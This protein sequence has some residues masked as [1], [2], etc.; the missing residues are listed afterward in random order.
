MSQIPFK[1]K[2]PY[3]YIPYGCTGYF[4]SKKPDNLF[5]KIILFLY[6]LLVDK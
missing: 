3:T 1:R 5:D 4:N 6:K 2:R